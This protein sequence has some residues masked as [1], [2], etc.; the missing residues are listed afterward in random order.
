[1]EWTSN[2]V[3]MG[4]GKTFFFNVY[5]LL[6]ERERQNTWGRG[7][8]RDTELKLGP[9]SELSAQIPRQMG[10]KRTSCEIMTWVEIRSSTSE[11]SWCPREDF[12]L[13]SEG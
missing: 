10:L 11:P 12:H 7:R 5:I 13:I 9:G 4:S 8:E 3:F 2:S 6:R 1:M